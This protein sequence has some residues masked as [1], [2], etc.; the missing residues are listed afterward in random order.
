M[1][2]HIDGKLIRALGGLATPGDKAMQK[3]QSYVHVRPH[4]D[5]DRCILEVLTAQCYL[6]VEKP[7]ASDQAVLIERDETQRILPKD[8]IVIDG[9]CIIRP[10]TLALDPSDGSGSR[11][12]EFPETDGYRPDTTQ[13]VAFSFGPREMADLCKAIHAAG[14]TTC[15]LLL[16]A[17]RGGP[18]GFRGRCAEN[19]AI[20]VE[21]AFLPKD[22]FGAKQGEEPGDATAQGS[23]SPSDMPLLEHREVRELPLDDGP[24]A[25]P[26]DG[27]E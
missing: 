13:R 24:Q 15:E 21:A 23:E 16:P 11:K 3:H 17:H 27:D 14:V 22:L 12:V 10:H 18:I 2:N 8:T 6:R 1:P 20:E 4:A 5:E 19:D 26:Y 7:E 25:L 9:N